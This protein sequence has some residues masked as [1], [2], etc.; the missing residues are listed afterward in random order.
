MVSPDEVIGVVGDSDQGQSDQRGFRQ[1]EALYSSLF[2]NARRSACCCLSSA[3]RQ[4]CSLHD[5][6]DLPRTTC[7][8]SLTLS[9]RNPVRNTVCR[10][11]RMSQARWKACD[12]D[13]A[14]ES[15][16][17]VRDC[18]RLSSV[19]EGNGTVCLPGEA[20]VRRRLPPCRSLAKCRSISGCVRLREF[21]IGR[22]VA[23]RLGRLAVL[24]QRPQRREETVGQLLDRRAAVHVL[25]VLQRQPQTAVADQAVHVQQMT[26]GGPRA[27]CRSLRFPR[28]PESR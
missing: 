23:A 7:T 17:Q 15:K 18:T 26:A 24:N 1:V 16:H 13:R 20:T 22:R 5:A 28:P 2:R 12:I 4:S 27:L 3:P 8:D 21:E 6:L 11:I 10:A 25:A 9:Q 14:I 19:H